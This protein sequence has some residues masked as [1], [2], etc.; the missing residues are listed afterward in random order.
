M[1]PQALPLLRLVKRNAH[2]STRYAVS[3]VPFNSTP[4]QL[5]ASGRARRSARAVPGSVDKSTSTQH[6]GSAPRSSSFRSGSHDN[7]DASFTPRPAARAERRATAMVWAWTSRPMYLMIGTMSGGDK[8]LGTPWREGR[9]AGHNLVDSFLRSR[10]NNP[11]LNEPSP[12]LF[13]KPSSHRG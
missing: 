9:L 8:V 7:W 11:R 12:T 13:L 3:I 2:R 4:A 5:S 10:W 6:T 1:E